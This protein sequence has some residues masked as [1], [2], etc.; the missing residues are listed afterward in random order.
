M[1]PKK[2]NLNFN[3]SKNWVHPDELK[4]FEKDLRSFVYAKDSTLRK[5]IH[6][7]VK[8]GSKQSPEDFI[9]TQLKMMRSS[10]RIHHYMKF[11]GYKEF[12]DAA[13][14]E[15]YHTPQFYWNAFKGG[16]Y[17]FY[18]IE[19]C[20]CL[21]CCGLII[22]DTQNPEAYSRFVEY[23]KRMKGPTVH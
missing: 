11:R 16:C 17:T 7:V 8:D 19:C 9:N 5:R 2:K 14:E 18:G 10:H 6:N 23:E 20:S 3:D 22:K 13:E 15:K 21:E 12:P 1:I 4:E